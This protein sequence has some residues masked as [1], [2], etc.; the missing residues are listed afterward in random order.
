[1][2]I[3][4]KRISVVVQG[5]IHHQESLTKRVLES[6]RQ[7]LPDA[8]L[9]LSTWKGSDVSGLEYDILIEND[10]PGA[11]NGNNVN[12]QIVSTRSGLEK[13]AREYAIKMRT[14]TL[15]KGS[16]FIQAFDLFPERRKD[17]KVFE[18]KIVIPTLY[19]RN[20]RRSYLFHPSDIF[21]FGLLSD[22]LRFW[23]VD[24]FRRETDIHSAFVSPPEQFIWLSCLRDSGFSFD[25]NLKSLS[26]KLAFYSEVSIFNNFI[27]VDIDQIDIRLPEKFKGSSG[28]H[29]CYSESE[30]LN[31]YCHYCVKKSDSLTFADWIYFSLKFFITKLSLS[32]PRVSKF[33]SD[34]GL[35]DAYSRALGISK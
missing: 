23:R 19:A 13:A 14:D 26:A 1:M 20:P 18:R 7:H 4:S 5:P 12:R 15:L 11:I 28:P 31:A 22:L 9:I 21:Q 10:D 33:F 29:L 2:I 6:V 8:E 32:F 24:L 25:Y 17:F 3:S 35:R 34:I 16:Q 30:I 27:I